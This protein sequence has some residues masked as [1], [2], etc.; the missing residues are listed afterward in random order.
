[1]ILSYCFAISWSKSNYK[2]RWRIMKNI[3]RRQVDGWWKIMKTL[4]QLKFIKTLVQLKFMTT[5]VQLKLLK[6]WCR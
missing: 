4:V 5:L 6:P 2:R 3:G 1:M